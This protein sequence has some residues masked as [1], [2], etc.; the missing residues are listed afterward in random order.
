[1]NQMSF[2]EGNSTMPELEDTG[3]EHHD[4]NDHEGVIAGEDDNDNL[5][6]TME[7][8]DNQPQ[9]AKETTHRKD[10]GVGVFIYWDRTIHTREVRE[11]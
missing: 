11:Y 8:N 2:E 9:P 3:Q 5:Q 10:R 1:M 6:Q 7:A 4:T